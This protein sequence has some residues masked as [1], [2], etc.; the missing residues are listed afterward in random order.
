MSISSYVSVEQPNALLRIPPWV[1]LIGPYVGLLI[2][3]VAAPLSNLVLLSFYTYSPVRIWTP[4]FTLD[5]YQQV[6]T[7]YF[8]SI[9]IRTLRIGAIATGICVIIGYPVAYYLARCS[10]RALIVGMFILIM[11]LMVSAVVGAFGWIVILGRNGLLNAA[12]KLVGIELPLLGSLHGS[13][14]GGC[15]RT[16]SPAA[17][18]LAADGID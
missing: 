1:W 15:A 10:K 8:G 9:A 5:N 17:H 18:G 2:A 11:P 14:R 4:E 16:L 12:A 13:S 6:F 7:P 3:F